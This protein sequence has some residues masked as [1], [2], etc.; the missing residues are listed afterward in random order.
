MSRWTGA[1]V[2]RRTRLRLLGLGSLA[3]GFA[4]LLECSSA[5]GQTKQLEP[6]FSSELGQQNLS[7][8]AAP[9]ADIKAVLV[10]DP[11]LMVELKRWVAE[12]ATNH[13]QLISESDLTDDAIYN[14]LD[15][16]IHFRGVATLLLQQY[17]YLAP[18]VN[19][20]SPAGK[21]QE[22]LIQERV[23]W[24][25]QEEEEAREQQR[26]DQQQRVKDLEKARACADGAGTNCPKQTEQRQSMQQLLTGAPAN[27]NAAPTLPD[28]EPFGPLPSAPSIP[29]PPNGDNGSLE[30]AQLLQTGAGHSPELS[31]FGAK[32]GSSVGGSSLDQM[33]GGLFSP[34][35]ANSPAMMQ[36]MGG[37]SGDEFSSLGPSQSLLS[38]GGGTGSLGGSFGSMGGVGGISPLGAELYS[39]PQPRGLETMSPAYPSGTPVIPALSYSPGTQPASTSEMT[40]ERVANPYR[41]I[42]SLYDR[43]LQALPRSPSPQRF[44]ANVFEN[45]M[46]DPQLIPMDLPAGPNYVVGPGDGLLIDLWG[47]I[48]SRIFRTVDREG[49]V[50]LPE[51]GP[52]MVSGKTLANAQQ[53]IQQDLRTQF[54]DISAAV[55]ISR[56]RTIQVYVVGDVAKPGAYDISSLSTPLNALFAA[57]G[58]T[59]TGSYRI[60]EHYRGNQ[61]IQTVDLYDLLLHGVRSDIQ[62]LTSGDTVLVPA[63]GAQVSVE[64]MVRRPA[65]YELKGETNLKDIIELAGG[66]LPIATLRHI[67][68]QRLVAHKQETMLSLNVPES[69]ND[70]QATKELESFKVQDGDQIRV[71]PIAQGNDDAVY[72]EGH[73]IRP[74]RYAF[75]N[76]M[77]V[78]DLISSFKDLL[79]EPALQYAEIIRLNEP[80]L[81]PTMQSFDLSNA[82]AHPSQAPVLH[83][84]DTVRIFS[85]FDFQN[86][87][88]VAVLGDVRQPGIYRTSGEIH[89]SDAIHLAGGLAPDAEREDVQIFRQFPGGKAQ[90]F[91]VNLDAALAGDQTQN[92]MLDSRDRVLIHQSPDAAE[93]AVVYIQGAIGRPGRYPLTS[94]MTV[95]DL[96]H[97]GGGLLPSADTKVGDL[98]RYQWE[99]Q[100]K[101]TGA[102]KP[103]DLTEALNGKSES[104][105]ALRNGDV[106]TIRQVPGW[107]DLGASIK[108]SGEVQHP[109]TYGIRPGERL[110]SVIE[111]AGGFRPGAY[112]YGAVLQRVE[113]RDV[114]QKQQNQL[115]LRVKDAEGALTNL[116][117]TT[118]QQRQTKEAALAQ[119]QTTI[120]EL[121]TSSPLG[122]VTIRISPKIKQWKNTPAD[123]QVRAGDTLFIPKRPGFV[124]VTGQVFDA[125]AVS[126][127]PGRSAKWYLEQS[128]GPTTIADKKAIFVIRADGSVIGEKKTLWIGDSLNAVL[129]P[130]D[131]VVVPEKAIGGG[132][133]WQNIFTSAELAS[134]ITSTLYIALHY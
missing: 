52:V 4:L 42:P 15:N 50:A 89:L 111:R 23:K 87:P 124:M 130:G 54:R 102:N 18:V 112:P 56:L 24:V 67:E 63:I 35:L 88:T 60:V 32:P 39:P 91:S 58:P 10:K 108:I 45:G 70:A 44:G 22:L 30:L 132:P 33:N 27:P 77:R 84:M 81:H 37:S 64:G 113:V 118:P 90:I 110:G 105:M 29:A 2:L 62:P 11:G 5:I 59:S 86:P 93:P 125:T 96:V 43:Y 85:R 92:I 49:R 83:A 121:S 20:D 25:S 26:Q 46:R 66:L 74:G 127:S 51:V 109:G 95:A 79:P 104:S 14:R 101:L 97:V 53:T 16:D 68:V 82:L 129:E 106:V 7:L 94:N 55:S 128:G 38:S 134:S 103:I 61:L 114:E 13:G 133:N 36:R 78:T 98:T 21:E 65:I 119:Y 75:H 34:E 9:S 126:Y 48:S 17:G 69:D 100:D 19:P 31:G 73:V 72:L 71:F 80:D 41:D 116:P 40:M 8:V 57:G 28:V 107:N 117:E 115:I 120:T 12:D 3:V 47:G 99:G 1:G 6:P 123:I 76:G 131:T 122:R